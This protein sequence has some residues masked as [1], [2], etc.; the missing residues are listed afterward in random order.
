MKYAIV[1]VGYNR[2][3][4]ME[5]LLT[6]LEKAIYEKSCDLIISLD[7][8]DIQD[9]LIE[10]SDKV[11]WKNGKKIIR[12]FKE[13][14][15]LRRHIL[16]CGDLTNKYDAVI[17]LEDDLVVAEG[18]FQYVCEAV[19]FYKDDEKIA[20]ISLYTHRTNPGNGRP[21]EAQNNGKD[22]FL[23]QYAMSWGQCWTKKMWDGFKKWYE[24]NQEIVKDGVIPEYIANWNKQSWLKY[25]IRYTAEKQLYYVYPYFSLTTNSSE[26]GEHNNK[27][28][29]A[30]QVPLS[31][32]NIKNYR[33]SRVQD[34]IKYDSYFERILDN[35]FSL[36]NKKVL[37]D[38]YGLRREF[39]NADILISTQ[40]LNYKIIDELEL[41]YRPHEVNYF[42]PEKG[43]GI[44]VYD[45]SE[46]KNNISKGNKLEIV[47]YDVKAESAR[48][49]LIHG[50]YGLKVK[51]LNILKKLKLKS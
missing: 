51:V 48:L 49:T 9:K 11:I 24:E 27:S 16:Q 21:F 35:N 29:S 44:F 1:V 28:N 17:V 20:G 23:M 39:F 42:I 12:T 18:F 6:S 40:K 8:S 46:E 37:L 30:Y 38:L 25:Y 33:F 10:I 3:T 13:K 50:L 15:G 7:Y 2:S 41:K 26:V 36:E 22:V 14:Q 45:L 31:F 5:R 47:S 34:A 32:G 43:R 19:E 4:S